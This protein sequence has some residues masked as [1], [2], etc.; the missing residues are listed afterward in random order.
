MVTAAWLTQTT[1]WSRGG[2]RI[3]FRR[4]CTRLLLYFN[5]DKPH[6]FFLRNTSCIR[7]P[8]VIS[9]VGGGGGVRTPCT[10]PLDPP[11]NRKTSRL[12]FS[13]HHHN[14]IL[15][16]IHKNELRIHCQPGKHL[17]H[18]VSFR[19]F[20]L[21]LRLDY[22]SSLASALNCFWYLD[23]ELTCVAGARKQ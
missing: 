10:L 2:S 1:L 22:Q 3:F 19:N 6:I 16:K 14:C 13:S 18:L 9:G 4:G 7:K 11:L 15:Q 5:T 17:F 21:P 8:Q 20:R 23:Y 12:L